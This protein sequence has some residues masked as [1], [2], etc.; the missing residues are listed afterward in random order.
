M[1]KVG[2]IIVSEDVIGDGNEMVIRKPYNIISPYSVPG[3]FSFV[4]SCS[5][6][7]LNVNETY[8]MKIQIIEPDESSIL[9]NQEFDFQFSPPPGEVGIVQSGT[10]NLKFNNIIFNKIGTHTFKVTINDK[11]SN[12]TLVPV[13]PSGR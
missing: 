5:L 7:E 13:L 9:V 2:Y 12:K 6:I 8:K 11:F 10:L 1:A 4:L 3:N